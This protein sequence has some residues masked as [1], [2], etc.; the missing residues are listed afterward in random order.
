MKR[1]LSTNLD[2]M[3][4][5]TKVI[6]ISK[7]VLVSGGGAEISQNDQDYH[8]DSSI[9][10]VDV[11]VEVSYGFDEQGQFEVKDYNILA[12]DNFNQYLRGPKAEYF[13]EY[14]QATIVEDIAMRGANM[15]VESKNG[16]TSLITD[17]DMDIKEV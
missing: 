16:D 13:D 15:W 3:D 1:I 8:Q 6:M 4:E 10:E 7:T 17:L 5:L 9:V 14:I 12:V 11:E 2:L